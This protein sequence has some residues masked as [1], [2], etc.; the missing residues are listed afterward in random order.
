MAAKKWLVGCLVVLL[1][2]IGG[3]VAAWV[4]VVKPMWRAGVEE[5]TA[6]ASAVDL[7][8][9]IRNQAPFDP[10]ADGRLDQAQADA[11]VRVQSVVMDEMGPDL[12]RLV[13]M[14]NAAMQQ[15]A[16]DGK[17]PSLSDLGA[18][19]G[20]ATGLVARWRAAQAKG[21][22]ATG[23]SREEY[24]WVRRQSLLAMSQLVDPAA[25]AGMVDLPPGVP[26]IGT[27]DP[28]DEAALA[29]ARHN[30]AL[31]RPHLPLLQQTLGGAP[32]QP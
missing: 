10:P 8:D 17:G 27:P 26:R 29:A 19:Y 31:L 7:G 15:R 28:G 3:A 24:A 9:D 14:G 18:A 30:A 4:F 2:F 20:E 22:N 25:L 13:G 11:F 1:V 12:A 5:A 16:A 23:L 32:A 6:W 21:I